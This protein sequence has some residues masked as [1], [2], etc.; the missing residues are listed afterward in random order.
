MDWYFWL[1]ISDYSK[2]QYNAHRQHNNGFG[3][4]NNIFFIFLKINSAGFYFFLFFCPFDVLQK[5]ISSNHMMMLMVNHI[6]LILHLHSFIW[7]KCQISEMDQISEVEKQ[8]QQQPHFVTLF[9]SNWILLFHS[10]IR[11]WLKFSLHFATKIMPF[12]ICHCIHRRQRRNLQCH[13]HHRHRWRQN[14]NFKVCSN[15]S[16]FFYEFFPNFRFGNQCVKH[17]AF[18]LS[19]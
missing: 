19:F 14:F 9:L 11:R 15:F 1:M 4:L 16:C 6:E 5:K 8:K 12:T 17:V 3:W 2:Y 7:K 18:F 10:F 13:H